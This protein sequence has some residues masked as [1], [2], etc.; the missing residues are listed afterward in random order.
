MHR[1]GDDM[2]VSPGELSSLLQAAT[3]GP[4]GLR[5]RESDDETAPLPVADD[6]WL[7]TAIAALANPAKRVDGQ[8][9]IG[10]SSVLRSVYAWGSVDDE[11]VF[12]VTDRISTLRISEWSSESLQIMAKDVLASSG[13]TDSVLVSVEL[14]A[15][16]LVVWLAAVEQVLAMRLQATLAHEATPTLLSREAL[17]ARL[18]E[19]ILDDVRWPLMFLSRVMPAPIG[20]AV[21][22]AELDAA[23]QELIAV[24]L[25]E[26]VDDSG[27]MGLY[28]LSQK[29]SWIAD[30]T[31]TDVSR[32]AVGIS[33]HR[34]D[35]AIGYESMMFVR[36]P[37]HAIL[38]DVGGEAAAIA[39]ASE[40]ALDALIAD[41]FAPPATVAAQGG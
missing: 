16:G 6:P 27:T 9:L 36:S 39:T 14:S 26:A 2:I 15:V 23:L 22:E 5:P 11:R 40:E 41:V 29:G 18:D 19:S 37:L 32:L 4:L 12:S 17:R 1:D 7:S 34:S 38:Y 33:V 21:D 20:A 28:E 13:A 25:L 8:S 10:R 3:A 24:D 35:G 30:E 31:L